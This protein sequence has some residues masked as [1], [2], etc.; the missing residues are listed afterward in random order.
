MTCVVGMPHPRW[1]ERPVAIV[2]MQ[3]GVPPISKAQVDEHLLNVSGR[4]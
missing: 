3:D 1:D 2:V 4:P